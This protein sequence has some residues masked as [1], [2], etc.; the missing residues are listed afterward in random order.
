MLI[1]PANYTDD[2]SMQYDLQNRVYIYIVLLLM[3]LLILVMII[4]VIVIVIFVF[5]KPDKAEINFLMSQGFS[6]EKVI[7]FNDIII[8]KITIRL[9]SFIYIS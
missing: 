3:N 7:Y 2:Q 8:I 1:I 5:L 9:S 4:I 6:K